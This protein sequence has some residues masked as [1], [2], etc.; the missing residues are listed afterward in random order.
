MK[1]RIK[2][3]LIANRGE[4]A[5]RVMRTCKEL[6][7]QTVA[8]YSEADKTAPHVYLADESYFIGPPPAKESYLVIDKIVEIAIKSKA[9]AIH[10]GYGFLSE[11]SDFVDAITSN[12]ILFIGPTAQSMNLLGDKTLARKLALSAGVPIAPGTTEPITAISEA[13]SISSK[14]G[15]PVLLK[16]AGGGGGKGMRV[17]RNENE[18]ESSLKQARSE[19]ASSFD[20]DR[21]FIEKYIEN[22]RHIEV[23]I[24]ADEFGNVVHLGERECSIQRRHQKII[25]ESPSIAISQLLRNE[26]TTAA[27][28]LMKKAK[29]LNAGT[30]EFLLDANGKFYFMEVNTRLQVEHPVTEARTGI[31]IVAEQIRIAEGSPLS[32]QQSEIKFSGHAIECRIY[33]EDPRNE[34]FPSTGT[35]HWLKPSLGFG[36]REDRGVETGSEVLPFY[37]P[38]I[39]KLITWG[40]DRN[41][42]LN[43]MKR[44]LDEYELFGVETN[45][46]FCQW[47]MNHPEYQNG[48]FDTHFIA[49]HFV[50]ERDL[51]VQDN[52]LEQAMLAGLLN[53]K[54]AEQK[55][56]LQSTPSSISSRWKQQRKDI[57]H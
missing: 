52:I 16:A 1:K 33:A 48:E 39:S 14:I 28:S 22:P 15:Y 2:K 26:I 36:V 57:L 24:L 7:I 42:S 45:I 34:F 37:D 31:D 20:D 35:I 55:V 53:F 12:G 43:R 46:Q 23:Q 9:D 19:A 13:I 4:I 47:L 51:T 40:N 27:V 3:I 29:Y 50:G 41:E 32:F 49:N 25:E 54:K 56:L 6:G 44:V 38:L 30:V 8:V 5:I 17:V 10:P 18:L 11:N 21:I